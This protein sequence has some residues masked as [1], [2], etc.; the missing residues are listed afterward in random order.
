MKNF[1]KGQLLVQILVFASVALVLISGIA[2]WAKTNIIASRDVLLKERAIQLAEA[3]IDYY[4]WHLAHDQDDYTDGIGGPGP[5]IHDVRDR[6]GEI[7]GQFWLNITPPAI[8]STKVRI[9]SAGIPEDSSISRTI[10]VE[11]AIPSFAKYAVAADDFMRFGEETEVFGPIHSNKGIRF[12]GLA[13][14]AVTSAVADYNDPDH[15]GSNEFG[16]HTHVSPVDPLPPAA[17]PS[18]PDVFEVGRQFPVPA[19]DFVGITNDLANIKSDAQTAGR[20]FAPSSRQGYQIILKTNDTFDVYRVN[21][22]TSPPNN[23]DDGEDEEAGW[24]TWSI[25]TRQWVG[26]YAIPS[27]GL[28]FVED[29]VWVQGQINGARVTIASGRFPDNPSNR[30]Q[31]TI[32]S[33]LLYTN[34]DGSDVIAL[35][36]QGNINAGLSSENNLRI[37]SALVSQNGRVGRYYYESSCGSNYLR[38]EITLYGM[39]AS[40]K[41]YGFRWTCSGSY[42][43]GY[44]DRLIIYDANLLYGPP[45]SFPL[46]SDQYEILSWEEI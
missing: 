32:N 5:Y 27:N 20:Y 25:N 31:I 42:C 44:D 2:N 18:R 21:S 30:P 13:H 36:G 19:I 16:V 24:G 17:M 7:A 6:D 15:T 22:Q 14:N 37:D 10:R 3:G 23:C 4:R 38:D 1:Q 39:I 33:D 29:N 11:M 8:G 28:I 43:S 45:P 34:Y 35:I 41:R 12:D 9:E 40:S 26:N 46:T